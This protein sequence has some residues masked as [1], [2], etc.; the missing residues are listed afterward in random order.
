MKNKE[1]KTK[2]S[3]LGFEHSWVDITENIAY[4]TYPPSYP[5]KQEKCANCG[6]IRTHYSQTIKTIEYKMGKI[7]DKSSNITITDLSGNDTC[8]AEGLMETLNPEAR[9]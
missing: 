5:P 7:D 1:P 6:L 8:T 2:C 3:E 4:L 9:L